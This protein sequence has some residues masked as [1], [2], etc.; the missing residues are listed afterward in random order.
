MNFHIFCNV[1]NSSLFF[2]NVRKTYSH[3][4][5]IKNK[6]TFGDLNSQLNSANNEE[7]FLLP[8][9]LVDTVDY[10]LISQT[11]QITCQCHNFIISLIV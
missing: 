8:G 5:K 9:Y 10:H 6:N 1:P 3:E 2:L 11:C 7:H 4:N